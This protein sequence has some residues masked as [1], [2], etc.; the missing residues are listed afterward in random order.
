MCIH[1]D[2]TCEMTTTVAVDIQL[3]YIKRV[4]KQQSERQKHNTKQ[5]QA[6]VFHPAIQFGLNTVNKK[7][8][9]ILWFNK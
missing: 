7:K 4:T 3:S 6:Q 9:S 1:L 5:T 8:L 2:K